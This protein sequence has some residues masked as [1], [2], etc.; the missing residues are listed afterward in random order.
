GMLSGFNGMEIGGVLASLAVALIL[1]VF[2]QPL[3]ARLGVIDHPDN[4]RKIHPRPTPLTGG[5]AMMAPLLIWTALGL[6]W[7][8]VSD[9][10]PIPLAILVCGGGA[11]LVGFIDD[12]AS[13]SPS[14]RFVALLLLSVLALFLS[15]Q[16]LPSQ[17]HWG[18]LASSHVAPW[19][20]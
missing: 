19:A 1:L 9:G 20:S 7:P 2:A 6:A 16:L 5:I 4:H 10:A 11:A 17:F 12:R 13:Y 15:P 14:V 8:A 18:H 3:G